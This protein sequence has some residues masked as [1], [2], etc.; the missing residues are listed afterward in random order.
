MAHKPFDQAD[1]TKAYAKL[2]FLV[3]DDFDNFRLSM[4]QMLRS[5][6]ADRIEVASNG[7]DAVHQCTYERFDMI[8][9]DYNLGEG[10][11]GQQILEELRHR[12]L[13]RKTSLF[14]MITAE[15]SREMVMG[16][17]EYQPDAYITKPITR[18][19]LE[20]R[21]SSLIE[22]RQILYDLNR[23]LDV[24][25]HPRAITL[26]REIMQ[27][28]PRYR[29]M[30]L[31][32]LAD[33]YFRTGDYTH[34]RRVYED[35]LQQRDLAWA[36]L[37]LARVLAAEGQN[38]EAAGS[39]TQLLAD[40]PEFMEAYDLL[41]RIQT[42]MGKDRQAQKTLEEAV[43]ISPNAILRQQS[44][45]Q[46]AA[47]NQD[48][49][50]AARA[51]R[52]TVKLGDHSVHDGAGHYLNLGR[53][54][55]ELSDGDTG[56]QGQKHAE[57]AI[58]VL[59]RLG[60]RFRDDETGKL[61]AMLI[62]SRVH[63]GQGR[64]DR[65]RELLEQAQ[66]AIDPEGVDPE[67]GLELA[68]TLYA[69]D[70]T[71]DAESLLNKL[72]QRFEEKPDIIARIEA[73]MDEPVGFQKRLKARGLNRDGIK[74]FETSQLA[75]AAAAFEKALEMVPRHPALN[76]N[77]V[78]VLLKQIDSSGNGDRLLRQCRE[79]LQQ[80]AHIPTQHRQYK[81]YQYL[82]NKVGQLKQ[83]GR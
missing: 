19:T 31:R 80:V 45:G 67:T 44:L 66:A 26:C 27:S 35:V 75:E 9:C 47:G 63:S 11:S 29:S 24:E 76:L 17:R 60:R 53:C 1:L 5:F 2:R 79:R 71:D 22:Q 52:S 82:L 64:Q 40:H 42:E 74:A 57:E 18:A 51:F 8:L 33:L 38:E 7:N 78:Q 50:T 30:L 49:E 61:N 46:I 12:K 20:K 54:L 55:A 14:V 6:G 4:K 65:S 62:E 36:R 3:V 77:L 37:G 70:N 48:M 23:E 73:L 32:T 10:K 13:I 81:R 83:S 16:A 72:A 41:A 15:T 39:L 59:N 34:A 68:R 25:N 21:L 56:E 69:H 28:H 58:S 43:R